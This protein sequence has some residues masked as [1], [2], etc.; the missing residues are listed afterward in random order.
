MQDL[1]VRLFGWRALMIHGDPCV[2]DRYR[3]VRGRLR[4]DGLAMLDAG[5][6]N[7]GF[8]ILAAKLGNE[9][10]G[11]SFSAGEMD[12]AARRA[13]LC[14]A[15][16]AGFEIRDLRSV[17][18]EGLGDF[19]EILCLE[20]I[21]HLL[22]DAGLM[23]KLAASLK[24]GGRI[25]LTTPYASHRPLRGE[26]LS[27]SED[28]GHVRWGYSEAKLR[29][30]AVGASLQ[31]VEVGYVSGFVSQRLTDVQ[32]RLAA[33]NRVLGWGLTLPLRV[34]Q[35]FDRPLTRLLDYPWLSIALVAE[36]PPGP[37]S[38]PARSAT[39]SQTIRR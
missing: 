36:R 7:G 22:D 24:P 18:E 20:V 4:R 17:G 10:L 37:A 30:L 25:L 28:G 12:A 15:G 31:A 5:A 19:D 3:W 38:R 11:L 35:P 16:G 2:W 29:E 33:R 13:R 14:G 34:L 8:T 32:R 1:L 27:T 9:C 39:N 26:R 23:R 21:E 6:G